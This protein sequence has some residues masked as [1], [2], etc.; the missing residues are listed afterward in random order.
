VKR[1]RESGNVSPL[2]RKKERSIKSRAWKD[3]ASG[4]VGWEGRLGTKGSRKEK[5]EGESKE[6]G[7]ILWR[8]ARRKKE[9]SDSSCKNKLSGKGKGGNGG[10]SGMSR[11]VLEGALDSVGEG[12]PIRRCLSLRSFQGETPKKG[13]MCGVRSWK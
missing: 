5:K 9:K 10:T 1:E 8:V 4:K 11:G 7:G 12:G 3:E 6:E 2:S 13:R